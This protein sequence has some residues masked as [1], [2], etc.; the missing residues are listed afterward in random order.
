MIIPGSNGLIHLSVPVVGGRKVNL[1]YKDVLIDHSGNWQRD[2]LRTILSVYGKSAWGLHYFES[3]EAI[4]S[5]R[6]KFLFDWNL[7]C[8]DW[9]CSKLKIAIDIKD[10]DFFADDQ[11]TLDLTDQFTPS[12]YMKIMNPGIQYFQV[13]ED[14]IGFHSNMSSI[15]LLM[16]EGPSCVHKIL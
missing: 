7:N 1:L 16:N 13:F 12:N 9:I 15:D 14:K 2:H 6:E 3:L 8:L 5:K 10:T 4:Y 11:I